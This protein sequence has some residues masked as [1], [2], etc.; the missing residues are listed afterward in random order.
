MVRGSLLSFALLSFSITGDAFAQGATGGSI[1]NDN[2]SLSGSREERSVSPPKRERTDRAPRREAEPRRAPAPRRDSG[3]GGVERFNGTWTVT[4]FGTTCSDSLTI[5]STI[6][7]GRVTSPYD[8]GT[9]SP[10]GSVRTI[11]NYSGITVTAQGRST[12]TSASGTFQRSDGCVGRW[13]SV[14]R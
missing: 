5:T 3:G 11:G 7:N 13:S 12:A 1:G 14:K 2:K 8:T 9:I 6:S 4:S 10:D